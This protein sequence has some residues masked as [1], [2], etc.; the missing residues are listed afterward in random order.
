MR[1]LY[2]RLIAEGRD[3]VAAFQ[4]SA[5]FLDVGTPADYLR[6]VAVVAARERRPLD[7]GSDTEVAGGAH[8]Q[9]SVLWDRVIV[10][11]DASLT[12]CVVADDV[13]VPGGGHYTRS[14]LVAGRDGLVVRPF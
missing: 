4:S 1:T 14:A 7:R 9:D 2:P 13:V 12:S 11:A 5:E 10:P 3:A 8:V 6:T